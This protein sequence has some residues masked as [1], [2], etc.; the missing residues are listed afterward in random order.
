VKTILLLHGF[1]S[2][3]QSTKASYL[4]ERL[5]AHPK[6]RFY[7]IDFNPT[8]RDFECVTVTGMIN[9]LRQYL[10]DHGLEECCLIGS[11]M[12]ALIG[13]N[14]AHQFGGVSRMLLL[15]PALFYRARG[16]DDEKLETWESDGVTPVY[17]YAFKQEVPLRYDLALD[18]MHYDEP[19]P[20]A[21]PTL[22]IHGR[23]DDIV[24]IDDSR[25]YVARYRQVQLI[26]VDA[27]HRLN[28]RLPFIWRQVQSFL[29]G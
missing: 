29:L 17:H 21:A 27:G 13:T 7:A 24:P 14:Y 11:S 16:M 26:E 19:V 10:L 9:R 20:P 15:A 18:G 8:P 6:A 23:H 12:G 28:D 2:S 4:R 22:I 3:G 25:E 1:A 5:R